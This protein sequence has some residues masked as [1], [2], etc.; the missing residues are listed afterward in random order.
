MFKNDRERLMKLIGQIKQ[1]SDRELPVTLR[2]QI[3]AILTATLADINEEAKLYKK[4]TNESLLRSLLGGKR[5]RFL[6]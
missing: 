3:L 6:A 2:V 1:W 4:A 5:E